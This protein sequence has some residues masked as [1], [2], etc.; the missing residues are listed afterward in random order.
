MITEVAYDVL[1]ENRSYIFFKNPTHFVEN[2][3]C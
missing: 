1:E 3:K 2:Q